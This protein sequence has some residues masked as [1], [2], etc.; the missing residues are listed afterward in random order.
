[1]LCNSFT[2]AVSECHT[3]FFSLICFMYKTICE[4]FFIYKSIK[5]FTKNVQMYNKHNNNTNKY[6]QIER[7]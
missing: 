2:A 1:M 4:V 3:S 7:K 6:T 5:K